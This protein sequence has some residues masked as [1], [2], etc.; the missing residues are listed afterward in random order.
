MAETTPSLCWRLFTLA[1]RGHSA[2]EYEDAAAGHAQNGRF[3]VAD[4]ASESAFSGDWSRLLVQTFVQTPVTPKN[5]DEW[6]AP[7]QQRWADAI[8]GQP[9]PWYAEEKFQQGAF[10]AFLGVELRPRTPGIGWEWRAVAIG[11]CCLFQVRGDRLEAKFPMMRA[12]D[13]D[14]CPTL[15]GSRQRIGNG[16]PL[17]DRWAKGLVR[18]GD[19]M[20]CMSD[21]LAQWF[22]T[23]SEAGERPWREM[24]ECASAS[25]AQAAFA[26]WAERERENKQLR[27]DDLTLLVLEPCEPDEPKA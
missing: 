20:L 26:A 13:F 27:N 7:V 10:A 14:S 8:S 19:V 9:L 6:L 3:A 1:K 2:A 18:P 11:D 21:A 16:Q 22:L 17:Y 23:Q 12:R 15:L 24:I 25:D 4:G 5:W